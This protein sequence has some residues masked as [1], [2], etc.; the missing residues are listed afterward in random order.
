MYQQQCVSAPVCLPDMLKAGHLFFL[1]HL[2]VWCLRRVTVPSDNEVVITR[3]LA[4]G[5]PCC[6]VCLPMQGDV[7]K[8]HLNCQL[9]K[10]CMF[11]ARDCRFWL[12]FQ[13]SC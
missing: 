6:S 7:P 3:L 9:A 5:S 1:H 10:P 2:V 8:V 12:T 4:F 13:L 11:S